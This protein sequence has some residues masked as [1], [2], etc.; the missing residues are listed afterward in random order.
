MKAAFLSH[1]DINLY[2][3]RLS[4]MKA[5]IEKNYKV[6]AIIP[7]GKYFKEFQQHNIHPIEYESNR[8]NLNP[9]SDT[10]HCWQLYK[11]FTREH[12]NIL[13]TFTFK[14][15]V[16]GTIMG[17][18]AGIPTIINHITGLGI[19]YTLKGFKMT[20]LRW[21]SN[22]FY[23]ISFRFTNIIVFQNEDD[24][25]VLRPLIPKRK[26]VF[27]IKGT[28]VNTDY[29]SPEN[30][31]LKKVSFL[32]DK[33]K[34]SSDNIVVTIIARLLWSKGIREFLDASK[35]LSAQYSNLKFL[36]V[37]WLDKENPD[38]I[39]ENV[40]EQNKNNNVLFTGEISDIR[41]LLYLTDVYVLPS[42]REGIP[43]T[44]L[45]AMAMCKP[46][47][48]TN[49]PGCKETVE[50]GLNGFLIPRRNHHVLAEKL[51]KLIQDT[52]L[53]N[54]MGIESRKKVEREFSDKMVIK[55]IFELYS[56]NIISKNMPEG[57]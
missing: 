29:F 5:L 46:I 27:F 6:Y 47:I 20:L 49:A 54:R 42:Y 37:G 44:V 41:E 36:I 3:F 2:L 1:V 7:K 26:P 17:K 43:R 8:G 13:H 35:I 32:K 23:F 21:I 11:I 31:D 14:P 18:I 24:Y 30:V 22:V 28:G 40:I 57:H 4:W 52:G 34:I 12:F 33:F 9:V 48:T 53:R 45:E 15:N 16:Y 56:Q 55:N 50:E 38:G 10:I 25:N 39:D 19:V 51:E